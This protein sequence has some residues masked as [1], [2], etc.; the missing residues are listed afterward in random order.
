MRKHER[1]AFETGIPAPPCNI[2][3][4]R[5]MWRD[6]AIGESVLVDNY[7]RCKIRVGFKQCGWGF[8]YQRLAHNQY[9]VWRTDSNS[10]DN[11]KQI[12]SP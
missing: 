12:P 1:P 8:R 5:A 10:I 6:I 9:R 11:H 2:R 4:N 7:E 3:A